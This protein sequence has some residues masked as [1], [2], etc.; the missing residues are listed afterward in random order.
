MLDT[1]V[2]PDVLGLKAFYINAEPVR[3]LPGMAENIMRILV[4]DDS[5]EPRGFRNILLEDMTSK[6]VPAASAGDMSELRQLW[7]QSLFSEMSEHQN[8]SAGLAT[9]LQPVVYGYN[10]YYLRYDGVR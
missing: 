1:S 4:S 6:N 8:V 10:I 5:A 7:H 9:E 2:D 3:V